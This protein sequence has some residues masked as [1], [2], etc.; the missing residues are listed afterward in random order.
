MKYEL[1]QADNLCDE[2]INIYQKHQDE[3]YKKINNKLIKEKCNLSYEIPLSIDLS[4]SESTGWILV[5]DDW[6]FSK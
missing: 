1:E 2:F 3:I 4:F 5:E 6:V